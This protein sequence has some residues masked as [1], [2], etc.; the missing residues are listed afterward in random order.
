[1]VNLDNIG[2]AEILEK[3]SINIEGKKIVYYK[4]ISCTYGFY[5][6]FSDG[7][8]RFVC[9]SG[10]FSGQN[11]ISAKNPFKHFVNSKYMLME[12]RTIYQH[13][14]KNN[15]YMDLNLFL[16]EA[17]KDLGKYY[18]LSDNHSHFNLIKDEKLLNVIKEREQDNIID[19]NK[20]LKKLDKERMK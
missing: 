6:T 12:F 3:K 2:T 20:Y 18:F 17:S 8:I 19:I 13:L 11:I 15:G 5:Y 10:I 9:L 4:V 1:M 16:K 7:I 14:N